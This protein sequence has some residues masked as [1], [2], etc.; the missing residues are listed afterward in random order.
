MRIVTRGDL[1]GL[2]SSVLLSIV[3]N[4]K[5]ITFVHPKDVQDGLY[6][7]TEDDIIVNLPYV[8]N[9]G[10]WFDH[11]ISEESSL[12]S[13]G[14]FKGRFEMAPSTAQ[15]IYN[16]YRHPEFDRFK[17]MLEETDRFDSAQLRPDDVIDPQGWILLGYTIDPRTG[18]GPEF[19][20]Y[21]RWLVEYVKE[22]PIEKVLQHREVKK[23]AERVI[24]GQKRFRK[25]LQKYSRQD[26]KI[27]ITDLRKTDETDLPVGNRFI[28]FTMFPPCN[29][30][31]RLFRG[32]LGTIVIAVGHSIF[33]RTCSVNVGNLLK[34]YGGGGHIGAGTCQ[35]KPDKAE[36]VVSEIIGRLKQ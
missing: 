21:F 18:L 30:E 16:H 12:G 35:I 17:E 36:S 3:A 31:V 34:E 6:Q 26:G 10:L 25:L 5:E 1:D 15:V 19:Q 28:V 23:R 33:N 8:R 13:I 4:I 27:I 20:K 2:V 24:K 32:K 14:N 22:V 11:H 9:C 7:A 29:V